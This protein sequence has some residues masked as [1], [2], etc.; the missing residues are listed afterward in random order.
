MPRVIP[1]IGP[2]SS[3][4]QVRMLTIPVT[5]AAVGSPFLNGVAGGKYDWLS[6]EY[7]PKLNYL[8][9]L[10]LGACS[11]QQ[12]YKAVLPYFLC[13]HQ[14]RLTITIDDIRVCA[15]L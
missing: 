1:V 13:D 6:I 2:T 12:T 8:L 10:L 9:K 4:P 5:N 3:P 7:P 14:S 11:L 15:K